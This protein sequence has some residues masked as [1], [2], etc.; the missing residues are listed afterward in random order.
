MVNR[1]VRHNGQQHPRQHDELAANF[2]TQPAEEHECWCGN[3]QGNQDDVARLDKFNATG[4][5]NKGKGIKLARVPHHTLPH[6]GPKQG[7]QHHLHIG[8]FGEGVLKRIRR[9]LAFRLDF[10]E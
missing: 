10:A 7:Q 3:S 1:A 9:Y 5:F 4:F 6:G 8:A 2:I